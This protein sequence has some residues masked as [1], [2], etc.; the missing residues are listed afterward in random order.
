M[1]NNH[2]II[3][4]LKGIKYL[5]FEMPNPGAYVITASNGSGKTTL[6]HCIERLANT[7]VFNDN[8]IQHRSWNVDSFG[9]SQITFKSNNN[10]EVTYTYRRS[11]D[12]WRPTTL[13]AS[14]LTDFGYNNIVAMPPLGKRVYVQKKTIGGGFV[15]AAENELRVAM[16]KVLEN[17]VFLQLRKF[18][19]GETR[20]RGGIKRRSSFAFLLPKGFVTRNNKRT[21]TYYSESSFSLGEIFTLNLL[22]EVENIFDN[23]LLLI[24]ELEVALHPKVQINILRYLED[25]SR[26]KNLTVIIST[27]SSSLIKCAKSLI[28]LQNKGDGDIGVHYNCY[29]T[30]ALR[31]VAVEEDI[32]P[33]YVFFVEDTSAELY[34]R[35]K[36]KHYFIINPN[37]QQPLWKILPIGGYPEVL[38]FTH[39]AHQYLLQNRIGQY[40][41]LD[42][43]VIDVKN[44]LQQKGNDRTEA[45]NELFGLFISQANKIKYLSITPELGI[46]Q[47]I[48]N[49]I[50]EFQNLINQR[51]PDAVIDINQLLNHCA[52]EFPNPPNNVRTEAKNKI[53]WICN[54]ISETTNEDIRRT[55]QHLFASFA[56]NKYSIQENKNSLNQLFGPIFSHQGNQ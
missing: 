7:R 10:N 44:S 28:Y 22:F 46:W 43:D 1:T 13:T 48:C 3:K 51:F 14:T 34:L 18:K 26:G 19:I 31:E 50:A 24:D 33:D 38:R 55:K 16:S 41:F 23:S 49:H 21:Q 40:A 9:D 27:H 17:D 20:G 6:M 42:Q 2:I 32:L 4:N 39:R 47:W 35:E 5:D 52:I 11:S 45:E 25:K 30:L 37:R 29:P 54:A 12:T 36:I 15:K 53:S 56:F 8:F